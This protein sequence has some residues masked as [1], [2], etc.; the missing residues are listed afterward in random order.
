MEKTI[1]S[2]K[3]ELDNN[4]KISQLQKE[5]ANVHLDYSKY[6]E[7]KD[8]QI[9][10]INKDKISLIEKTNNKLMEIEEQKNKYEFKSGLLEEEN[11]AMVLE[12]KHQLKLMN[13]N[14]NAPINKNNTNFKYK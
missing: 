6:L 5:S 2:K 11:K 3:K 12:L 4:Q 10:N 14:I 13:N 9:E 8:R 1:L 7:I